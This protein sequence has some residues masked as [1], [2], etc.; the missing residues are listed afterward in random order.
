MSAMDH[1]V[2][3]VAEAAKDENAGVPG[4]EDRT[5]ADVPETKQDKSPTMPPV[6]PKIPSDHEVGQG[7]VDDGHDAERE[8]AREQYEQQR[9]D[10]EQ[11]EQNQSNQDP[12]LV[13]E[14]IVSGFQEGKKRVKVSALYNSMTSMHLV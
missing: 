3:D 1:Q 8:E 5:M 13:Q 10:D 6:T 4:R 12:E 7:D 9:Q 11:D 14:E 2:K